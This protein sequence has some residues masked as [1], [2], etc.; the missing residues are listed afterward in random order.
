[1]IPL[2]APDACELCFGTSVELVGSSFNKCALTLAAFALRLL[3]ATVLANW[4]PS[5]LICRAS[6][7]TGC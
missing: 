5:Q 3:S 4:S 7:F 2:I 6:I 1:M